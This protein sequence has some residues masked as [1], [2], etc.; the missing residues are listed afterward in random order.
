[1]KRSSETIETND[2]QGGEPLYNKALKPD[3]D[4]KV[5]Y[6]QMMDSTPITV[7]M[8]RRGPHKVWDIM[9]R[10]MQQE[11]I[12][13]L[14]QHM[15]A[16]CSS[17]SKGAK[18]PICGMLD[19][20]DVSAEQPILLQVKPVRRPGH[21]ESY[22][23]L[24]QVLNG[25]ERRIYMNDDE[26]ENAT[27]KPSS[28]LWAEYCRDRGFYSTAEFARWII[29]PME[30]D[31]LHYGE[32]RGQDYKPVKHHDGAADFRSA[33]AY[34]TRNFR[35]ILGNPFQEEGKS[36]YNKKYDTSSL[37]PTAGSSILDYGETVASYYGTHEGTAGIFL[38]YDDYDCR[39]F[40]EEFVKLWLFD[41]SAK[42]WMSPLDSTKYS[43]EHRPHIPGVDNRQQC[44]YGADHCCDVHRH[45]TSIL[46]LPILPTTA[47]PRLEHTLV[48]WCHDQLKQGKRY[49]GGPVNWLHDNIMSPDTP[50]T[51]FRPEQYSVVSLHHDQLY[52]S[53]DDDW[54]SVSSQQM[55]TMNVNGSSV[56]VVKITRNKR[57]Q[58]RLSR[59]RP[60][61]MTVAQDGIS[62]DF[63]N[64]MLKHLLPAYA[65]SDLGKAE[66]SDDG[67][68]FKEN[69]CRKRML[70]PLYYQPGGTS[71]VTLVQ[72]RWRTKVRKV[73]GVW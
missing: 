6:I 63:R 19:C 49:G 66:F 5:V 70:L 67:M 31:R 68:A 7:Q 61:L 15:F 30:D 33:L 72:R 20:V 59:L 3:V 32:R 65:A 18:L 51:V 55:Y 12:P 62:R 14:N 35:N 23:D 22:K 69:L 4:D 56:E 9:M 41:K 46:F 36:V 8:E 48:H 42:L 60:R 17:S 58:A 10:L 47:D 52:E 2:N 34:P 16:P 71:I 24:D 45:N 25:V 27:T 28:L 39:H 43:F 57:D 53:D 37:F 73:A 50:L 54:N 13:V 38:V 40:R 64:T 44:G 29:G 11:G 26:S 1:M 21:I